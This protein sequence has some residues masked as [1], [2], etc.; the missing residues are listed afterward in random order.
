MRANFAVSG[1]LF[2]LAEVEELVRTKSI[3]LKESKGKKSFF[4]AKKPTGAPALPIKINEHWSLLTQ[5]DVTKLA[6]TKIKNFRR[7]RLSLE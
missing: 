5:G 3:I 4:V 1:L 2:N 7:L 6:A